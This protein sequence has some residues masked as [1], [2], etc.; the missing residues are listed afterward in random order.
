MTK[1]EKWK[2]SEAHIFRQTKRHTR[3]LSWILKAKDWRK[4][5]GRERWGKM[6]AGGKQEIL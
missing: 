2:G 4:G 1:L 6:G 5:G 3:P